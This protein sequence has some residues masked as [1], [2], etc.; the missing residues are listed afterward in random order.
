MA[1]D[2]RAVDTLRRFEDQPGVNVPYGWAEAALSD[3]LIRDVQPGFACGAHN[4]TGAGTPHL[5]PMN[6]NEAGRIDLNVLK[7]VPRSV[8]DAMH[9]W[10]ERGDVLFNNTNSP[11]LVGKTAYYDEGEPRPFSN[12]MTR[13]RTDPLV[14]DPR[15][16]AHVL[17]YY[18]RTGYFAAHCNNHVS[19]ASIDRRVLLATR[20]PLPPLREQQ[21]IVTALESLLAKLDSSRGRLTG[22]PAILSRF[23]Q[24]VLAAACSGRLTADFRSS[25]PTPQPV[26]ALNRSTASVRTRRGVPEHVDV[27]DELKAHQLPG[28]WNLL[29]CSELL[30]RG[31]LIDVKDGNHG[32]NHPKSAELGSTGLPFITAAQVRGDGIDYDGAH[33]VDGVALSRLNVGFAQ[34]DDVI[35]THKG[36]VGRV[37]VNTQN[38]VL[39]PQTTYYR[40]AAGS[41]DP[42]YV[43]YFLESPYFYRQLA[44]VMSQTTRDFVP[45]SEQYLLFFFVPPLEEQREIGRRVRRLMDVA[46]TIEQSVA[47]AIELAALLSH[48]VVQKAFRGALV[49]GEAELAA[50]E[51]REFEPVQDLLDRLNAGRGVPGRERVSRRRVK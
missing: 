20:I 43:R 18:W 6:V 10:L 25:T 36:S 1:T 38:C 32:A 23:R 46:H 33:K 15:Y 12:H 45:I 40:C 50:K 37:A 9:R 42:T 22:V 13:L 35:L 49:P 26:P 39:T 7:Y 3:G 4:S 29:S 17:H 21:R 48:S 27:P 28:S 34:V 19:Q 16:C 8:A 51:G 31:A 41:L 24:A 11:E 30:R 5:R 14:L 2:D 47:R 44:A